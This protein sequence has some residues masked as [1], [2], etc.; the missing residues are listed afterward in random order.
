MRRVT[1]IELAKTEQVSASRSQ[2][3]LIINLLEH[4][5]RA[6]IER[7]CRATFADPYG[8]HANVNLLVKVTILITLVNGN[9]FKIS[10]GI[11]CRGMNTL[12]I[13]TICT[14]NCK[15]FPVIICKNLLIKY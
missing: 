11:M 14:N 2:S 12:K 4:S 13:G 8:K 5:L 3:K 7:D 9:V 1:I 15:P 10:V 6:R